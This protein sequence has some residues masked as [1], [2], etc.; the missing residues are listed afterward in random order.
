M[1]KLILFYRDECVSRVLFTRMSC[2]LIFFCF[3]VFLPAKFP[4]QVREAWRFFD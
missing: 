4:K 2:A 1:E 3:F